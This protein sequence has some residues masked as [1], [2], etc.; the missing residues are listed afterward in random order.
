MKE[1]ANSDGLWKGKQI[2]AI[3][4]SGTIDEVMPVARKLKAAYLKHGVVYR[5]S[6]FQ[7]KTSNANKPLLRS[8]SSRRGSAGKWS[9]ISIFD[10]S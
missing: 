7:P 1:A 4:H 3:S 6:Q 10:A 2:S 5:L 9:S 8:Q